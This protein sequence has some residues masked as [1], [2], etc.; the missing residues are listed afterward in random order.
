MSI[1]TNVPQ[2]KINV[3]TQSQ[4]DAAVKSATELYMITDAELLP[5]QTGQSGKFLTTNGTTASW[6]NIPSGTGGEFATYGTTT[7]AQLQE[8]YDDGKM[9][10]CI[11]LNQIHAL[12]ANTSS[13][14]IFAAVLP[15]EKI[16]YVNCS[17]DNSTWSNVERQIF[18]QCDIMPTATIT[19][20]GRI[21]QYSG[22]TTSSYT[23]GYCYIC[24]AQGTDPETYAW[25]QINIQP[26]GGATDDITIETNSEDKLQAI[27]TINKN[28]ETDATNPIY[29]WVGTLAEY[30]TQQ[31]KTLH[32]N[33]L[34]YITDDLDAS[35]SASN[36]DNSTIVLNN[37]DKIQAVAVVNSNNESGAINP[38]YDWVGTLQEY[39]DNN[40]ATIHPEYICYIIDD[41]SGGD[42]VYT[43]D[44]VDILVGERTPYDYVY[45]KTQSD[46]RYVAKSHEV[47]EFQA[48]DAS[49][50]YTWYRKYADGWVEQGGRGTLVSGSY[51]ANLSVMMADTNYFVFTGTD[52]VGVNNSVCSRKCTGKTTTTVTITGTYGQGGG[53][54]YDD[55]GTIW[56]V[57]GMFATN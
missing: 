1:T 28:T 16:R 26:G 29:D 2:V 22:T 10:Y 49:N 9:I 6:A 21:I 30:Q 50:N 43:K 52:V 41:Y 3:M 20:L 45:S 18:I 55:G 42:E 37:E 46:N 17:G 24:K 33:W 40:I 31:I 44:E 12:I 57:S 38:I 14:F 27:G 7:K 48:P 23:K 51:T 15:N 4:Y 34:C 53:T 13:A 32:P 25:E 35:E 39:Y 8:W 56:Q 11:Y 19:N 54:N 47:I 36:I 5:S